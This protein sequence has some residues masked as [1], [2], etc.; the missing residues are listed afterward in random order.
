MQN[1]RII[2]SAVRKASAHVE[3]D[4]ESNSIVNLHTHVQM[5]GL[6]HRAA[7]DNSRRDGRGG[8]H[9]GGPGFA[10]HAKGPSAH[11]FL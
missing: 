9:P 4:P 2:D 11:R 3:P 10:G 8:A 1:R 6:G 5:A 7:G